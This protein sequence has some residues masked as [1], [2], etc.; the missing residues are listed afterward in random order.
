MNWNCSSRIKFVMMMV[1]AI[2]GMLLTGCGKE[3]S[4]TDV[5]YAGPMLDNIL[6]GIA[7]QDYEKFSKDFS[8]NMKESVKENDFQALV[9]TL[10][11]KL[12]EYEER[13]FSNATQTK[14]AMDVMLVTY[15][16]RYSKESDVKITMYFSDSNGNK[17]IEGFLIDSPALE[18]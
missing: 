14:S 11:T 18:Q 13:S 4:E 6:E 15:Q 17:L 3:L 10:D 16:A 9:A 7:D 2:S 1:I 8:P 12:G 5:P